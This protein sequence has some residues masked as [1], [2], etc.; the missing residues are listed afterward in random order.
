[1]LRYRAEQEVLA[2]DAMVVGPVEFAAAPLVRSLQRRLWAAAGVDTK[3]RKPQR[4]V[5]L[6]RRRTNA[7]YLANSDAIEALA[8]QLG[9]DV[10]APE[11]LSLIDQ[12]RLSAHATGVAGQFGSNLTNL[13]FARPG[14]PVLGLVDETSRDSFFVNICASMDLP[15]RW[16]IGAHKNWWGPLDEAFEVD[17]TVLERELH[18]LMAEAS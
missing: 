16:L 3:R 15:Q 9:F 11:S 2:D 1:M 10:I 18:R 7:R 8:R 17:M 12:I 14:T 5:W 4:P 13:M 6:S